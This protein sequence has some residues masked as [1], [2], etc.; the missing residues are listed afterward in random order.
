MSLATLL[1]QLPYPDGEGIVRVV[2][3]ERGKESVTASRRPR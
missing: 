2:N 1:Q 3:E